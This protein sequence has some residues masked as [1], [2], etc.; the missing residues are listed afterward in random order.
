VDLLNCFAG[1]LG[2]LRSPKRCCRDPLAEQSQ[3]LQATQ[4]SGL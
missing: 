2:Q 1:L 3:R 4:L